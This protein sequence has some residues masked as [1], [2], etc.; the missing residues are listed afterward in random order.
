MQYT[1]KFPRH[2]A[3]ALSAEK[4][5]IGQGNSSAPPDYSYCLI[6]RR[7]AGQLTFSTDTTF[8]KARASI[9]EGRRSGARGPV[10]E[11]R[12]AA[13]SGEERRGEE[14]STFVRSR[15]CESENG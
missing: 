12:G 3:N 8:A 4:L 15:G 13:R 6:N 2:L 5:L 7:L 9:E 11:K 10:S 14:R 1:L